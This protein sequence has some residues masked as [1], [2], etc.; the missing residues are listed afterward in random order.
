[1]WWFILIHWYFRRGILGFNRQSISSTLVYCLS[2]VICGPSER[3]VGGLATLSSTPFLFILYYSVP[4]A[5]SPHRTA[6]EKTYTLFLLAV[7]SAQA[8]SYRSETRGFTLENRLFLGGRPFSISGSGMRTFFKFIKG[9][10]GEKQLRNTSINNEN[11]SVH[12][13]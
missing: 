6:D 1:M 12:F 10:M 8:E 5:F 11:L 9:I 7:R 4:S 2:K 13:G 3:K